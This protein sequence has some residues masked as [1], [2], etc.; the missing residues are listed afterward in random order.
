MPQALYLRV[1]RRAATTLGD[2]DALAVFLNVV[3]AKLEGW[4]SGVEPVPQDV[5]LACVDHLLDWE[6]AFARDQLF[7]ETQ[8][9]R[10]SEDSGDREA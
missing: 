7:D 5:F 4:L 10:K 1:L 8:G 9:T 2:G 6:F 3:P